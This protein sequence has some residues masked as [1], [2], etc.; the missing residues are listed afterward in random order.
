M[1][2]D[3]FEFQVIDEYFIQIYDNVLTAYDIFAATGCLLI[4][5][6]LHNE[7]RELSH[8]YFTFQN[9]INLQ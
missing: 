6:Q 5:N 4:N 9:K 1:L 8:T 2:Y 3:F 7:A